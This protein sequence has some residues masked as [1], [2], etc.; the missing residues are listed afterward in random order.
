MASSA[1]GTK[2]IAAVGLS[3]LF[4]GAAGYI[5]TSG[6]AGATW[7]KTGA[8]QYWTSVASSADGTRLVAVANGDYI[9]TL[10]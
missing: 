1:D 4:F 6:D 10:P 5:Y 7:T 3:V 9:Y 2:L 8:E